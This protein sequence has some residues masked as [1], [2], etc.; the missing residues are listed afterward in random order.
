MHAAGH[1]ISDMPSSIRMYMQYF[2]ILWW[3]KG[4]IVDVAAQSR[5]ELLW[6]VQ[7]EQYV[8]LASIRLRFALTFCDP[9]F[10]EEELELAER[11]LAFTSVLVGDRSHMYASVQCAVRVGK[12]VP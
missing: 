12:S 8:R 11:N 9:V 1:A 3:Y 6:S 5:A 4:T 2:A 7:T 10:M